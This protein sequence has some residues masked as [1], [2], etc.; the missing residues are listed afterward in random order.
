MIAL[1]PNNGLEIGQPVFILGKGFRNTS[2]SLACK[3]GPFINAG[4]YISDE[5]VLCV[6]P[7][8]PPGAIPVSV[9]MDGV[10]WSQQRILFHYRKCSEGSYCSHGDSEEVHMRNHLNIFVRLARRQKIFNNIFL[11]FSVQLVHFVLLMPYRITH[12][13]GMLTFL[14]SRF[15]K[16]SNF[17]LFISVLELISKLLGA[18]SALH[19]HQGDFAHT[20]ECDLQD[21]CAR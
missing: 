20:L 7:P 9:S 1:Y 19:A 6:A 21:S 4:L 15:S 3:F 5:I 14:Y 8:Q 18:L 17:S 10:T 16:R 11:V 12:Y 13:A 2:S